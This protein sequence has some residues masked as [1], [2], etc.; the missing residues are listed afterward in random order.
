M[1]K[2]YSISVN[3]WNHVK[4]HT[5]CVTFEYVKSKVFYICEVFISQFILCFYQGLQIS[6]LHFL[7]IL[8]YLEKLTKLDFISEKLFIC[9]LSINETY[10]QMCF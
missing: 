10:I 5:V 2:I 6:E 9:H 7:S 1:Y 8:I 4:Y 3:F